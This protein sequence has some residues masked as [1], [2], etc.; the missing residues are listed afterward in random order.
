M[1][2]D[3][4]KIGK[5]S[6]VYSVKKK[7]V[8]PKSTWHGQKKNHQPGDPQDFIRVNKFLNTNKFFF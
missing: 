5:G 1:S 6:S 4:D 8:I 3:L 7:Y 2:R